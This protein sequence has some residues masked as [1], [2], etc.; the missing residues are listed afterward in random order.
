[1]VSSCQDEVLETSSS[2]IEKRQVPDIEVVDMGIYVSGTRTG[3]SMPVLKFKNEQVYEQTLTKVSDMTY[4]QRL[5]FFKSL[6]FEGAFTTLYKADM[7]LDKIFDI[8]DENKFLTAYADFKKEYDGVFVYNSENQYDLSPYYSFDDEKAE[9]L[10]NI[11]GAV[12]IGNNVRYADNVATRGFLGIGKPARYGF[13]G[14]KGVEL[15]VA[16]G[17]YYSIVE[18][19]YSGPTGELN[20]FFRAFKKKRLWTRRHPATYNVDIEMRG[21]NTKLSG[22]YGWNMASRGIQSVRVPMGRYKTEF[23]STLNISLTNFRSSCTGDITS[24]ATFTNVPN[25]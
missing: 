15:T 22:P 21:G 25:R 16:Q 3:E 4:E 9:L 18:V 12:I 1:M 8:E 7:K 17:K 13:I 14:F 2:N 20:L 11:N 23:P 5:V 24:A 19:G 10:G 6:N